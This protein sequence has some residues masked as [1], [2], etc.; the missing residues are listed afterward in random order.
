V[1]FK[2]SRV[3]NQLRYEVKIVKKSG[4]DLYHVNPM[5][6]KSVIKATYEG[7]AGGEDNVVSSIGE[8]FAN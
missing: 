3:F 7:R 4:L 5:P 2:Q 8:V 6:S 1:K